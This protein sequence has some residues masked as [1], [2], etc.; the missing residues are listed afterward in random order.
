MA[1]VIGLLLRILPNHRFNQSPRSSKLPSNHQPKYNKL[2]LRAMCKRIYYRVYLGSIVALRLKLQKL[3]LSLASVS[4]A[5][6]KIQMTP[7]LI[8]YKSSSTSNGSRNNI[9]SSSSSCRISNSRI[10]FIKLSLSTQFQ[11]TSSLFLITSPL[12][13]TSN[14]FSSSNHR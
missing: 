11:A 4:Q 13:S 7:S 2:K 10:K 5:S 12:S 1:G 3:V 6:P 14:L 9:N 8:S